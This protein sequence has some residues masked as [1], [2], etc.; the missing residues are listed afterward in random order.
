[1]KTDARVLAALAIGLV[2]CHAEPVRASPCD[3]VAK[4]NLANTRIVATQLLPAGTFRPPT[5]RQRPSVEIFNGFDRLRAFCR[6]QAMITPTRDSHIRVE[7]WLPASGWNGRYLGVGNGGYAGSIAYPKLGE[8]VNSGYASASTDTGHEGDSR[9]SRWARGHPELQTDFD[10]RAVHEMTT[11]AKAA[12][13]AFYNKAPSR[14]YFS[15]CSNGGRQ[16]LMEAERYPTDYDGIMA[17]APAYHYGFNTFVSGRLDAFRDRGGKLVIYHGGSDAP[18]G[19][20]DYY[21]QLV[22]RMGKPRVDS[23]L[24]LYVV[25]GMGHCGSGEVPNDFGQW[26]RPNAAPRHSMLSSLELWVE[27]GVAPQ[28]IVAT[29]WRVDGDTASGVLRTRPLCPYPLKSRFTGGGSRNSALNYT[30][31]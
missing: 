17:G 18:A 6:L 2:A 22:A 15:S 19:S 8:A 13:A 29:Q 16:G 12:I 28:S 23:F 4:L 20:I 3:S 26:V 1:V 30:C 21:E 24:Q 25:P 5:G 7:V 9:D 31:S 27:S 11:L 10:Y 14:S